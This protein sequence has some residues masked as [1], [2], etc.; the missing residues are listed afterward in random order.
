MSIGARFTW[1]FFLISALL[2]ML[3]S[4]LLFF[5]A[6]TSREKAFY[7]ALYREART[8]SALVL[9]SGIQPQTLQQIY[10]NNRLY[11]NEVEVAIYTQSHRLV[12]HDAEELDWVKETPDMLHAIWH[13]GQ[14][15]T[16][17]GEKQA[18]GMV[19]WQDDTPYLVTAAAYDHNGHVGLQKVVQ[20][21]A[22]MLLFAFGIIGA[23]GYVFSKQS[24]RPLTTMVDQAK[25][26]SAAHMDRRLALTGSRDELAELAITINDLLDRLENS[27]ENQKQFVSHVAHEIRSPLTA[28]RTRIEVALHKTR[29][30]DYYKETLNQLLK[31]AKGLTKLVTGLLDLAKANYDPAT[32]HVKP[33]RVEE[34]L[35][36]ACHTLQ[37][38]NPAYRID[39][40]WL[41][42]LK[43]EICVRGNA[44]LLQCAFF[45]LMENACKYSHPPH[46]QVSLTLEK[47]HLVIHFEDQGIGIPVEDLPHLWTPFFRGKNGANSMGY[48][49]G[50]PLC[51]KIIE[52]H[53]GYLSLWSVQG[54]GCKVT[55][56]LP[57]QVE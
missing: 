23:M 50:L 19:Y 47:Q 15:E 53:K 13:N 44:Y 7:N 32:I 29:P 39:L 25:Q 46:V 6:R 28:L 34:L 35:L 30:E 33:L 49:L 14:I 36:E 10:D 3:F 9:T 57:Y 51:Q 24:L 4:A 16:Y 55:L 2:L 54:Q 5:A 12:Y 20:Q 56:K 38:A 43:E 31:D 37:Q 11:I 22:W 26:I 45:N 40:Q 27:M 21:S 18:I 17:V 48:G 41:T 52:L 8:K 42:P 1:L